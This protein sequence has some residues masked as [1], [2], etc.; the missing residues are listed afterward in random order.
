MRQRLCLCVLSAA[1]LSLPAAADQPQ[2]PAVTAP[3][4][5]FFER[6]RERDRDAARAFYKK[7]ID[8]NGMPVVAAADVADESLQRTYEIVTHLL[9]GR[10]DVLAAMVKN[11]TRLIVIGK[12]QVYTD[13]PEY[14]NHPNPAYRNERVRGTGG[15]EVTSFGEENLLNLAGDQIGRAHV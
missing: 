8:V 11:G 3:P 10:P 9:A 2:A 7:Y 4:A 6:V 15:L 14:R 5:S 12:D 1:V 13:M